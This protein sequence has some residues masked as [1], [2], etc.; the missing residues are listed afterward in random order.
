MKQSSQA[1][2][3]LLLIGLLTALSVGLAVVNLK[4][5]SDL[6]ECALEVQEDCPRVT[7]YA[8]S[9]ERENATVNVKLNAC[10]NILDGVFEQLGE[11]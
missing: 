2:A 11:K 3:I 6:K 5:M 10:R 4:L 9:L 1:L 8:L 7:D